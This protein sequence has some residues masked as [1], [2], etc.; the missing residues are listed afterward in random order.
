MN[1][2]FVIKKVKNLKIQEIY[3]IKLIKEHNN[4]KN[5]GSKH[6][7]IDKKYNLIIIKVK[8]KF[9]KV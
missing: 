8:N 6:K 2:I 5:N 3:E 4:L 1:K 7:L 9:R